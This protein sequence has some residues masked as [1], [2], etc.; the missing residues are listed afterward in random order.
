MK[1]D[2]VTNASHMLITINVIS[3]VRDRIELVLRRLFSLNLLAWFVI[4][5]TFVSC[6][7]S[8]WCS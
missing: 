1:D 6:P 2:N 7:L 8:Q 4:T 5:K 3:L